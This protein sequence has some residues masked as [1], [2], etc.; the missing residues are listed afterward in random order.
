[1][2]LFV[3]AGM[4]IWITRRRVGERAMDSTGWKDALIIGVF[5]ACAILPGIS[6]S[7]ATI[8]GALL[9]GLDRDAAPRFSF[10]LSVP[11]IFAGGLFD[12]KDTLTTGLTLP[13]LPL[14]VGFLAAATSGYFAVI[15]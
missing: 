11:I 6:R 13:A 1:M 8:T 14:L 9:R 3:T 4:L 10:L 12:L 15:C 7:G 5:Q 2:L